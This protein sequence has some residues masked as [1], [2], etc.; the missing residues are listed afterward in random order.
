M[1]LET[2]TD[3]SLKTYSHYYGAMILD[4]RWSFLCFFTCKFSLKIHHVIHNYAIIMDT[5]P[6]DQ[7]FSVEIQVNLARVAAKYSEMCKI[8]CTYS[9]ALVLCSHFVSY[10]NQTVKYFDCLHVTAKRLCDDSSLIRCLIWNGLKQPWKYVLHVFFFFFLLCV[11]KTFPDC[12]NH[13]SFFFSLL[14]YSL[15]LKAW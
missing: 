12:N 14:L 9:E 7:I 3:Y 8:Y 5:V 13:N 4:A 6:Q 11:F 10:L 1:Y 15:F 2:T